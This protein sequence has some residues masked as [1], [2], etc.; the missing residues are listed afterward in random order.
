M[1]IRTP[2]EIPPRDGR[3]CAVFVW[4]SLN[5]KQPIVCVRVPCSIICPTTLLGEA[6]FIS[7]FSQSSTTSTRSAAATSWAWWWTWTGGS[8]R[9][10]AHRGSRSPFFVNCGHCIGVR[11]ISN[12]SASST[13]LSI[14]IRQIQPSPQSP[15]SIIIVIIAILIGRSRG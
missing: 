11:D 3:S 14:P 1:P 10:T 2:G 13:L 15:P 9:G 6:V 12:T 7:L 8:G 5:V 4:L